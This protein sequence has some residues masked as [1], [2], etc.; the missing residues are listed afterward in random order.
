MAALASQ[1]LRLLARTWGQDSKG[2]QGVSML[3]TRTIW[4]RHPGVDVYS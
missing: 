3:V 1:P 4:A 2:T